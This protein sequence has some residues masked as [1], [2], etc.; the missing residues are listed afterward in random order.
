M[1]RV[2]RAGCSSACIVDTV[3]RKGLQETQQSSMSKTGCRVSSET[4]TN[5]ERE[6]GTRRV[7]GLSFLSSEEVGGSFS[8]MR[9]MEKLILEER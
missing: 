3:G 9:M 8:G 4:Q 5:C 6:K 1:G 2:S 7:P